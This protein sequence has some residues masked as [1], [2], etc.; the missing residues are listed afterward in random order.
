MGDSQLRGRSRT[1]EC[2]SSGGGY[3]EIR[4]FKSNGDAVD[5]YV[6]ARKEGPAGF[7]ICCFHVDANH[8]TAG[9][10]VA[11]YAG[12]FLVVQHGVGKFVYVGPNPFN[13]SGRIEISVGPGVGFFVPLGEGAPFETAT[14]WSWEGGRVS[15]DLIT[16]LIGPRPTVSPNDGVSSESASLAGTDS[17]SSLSLTSGGGRSTGSAGCTWP[18]GCK[19]N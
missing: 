16:P 11:L 5:I 6:M 1:T 17:S 9:F 12:E 13:A 19:P 4:C 8:A 7:E 2:E 18:P 10:D 14:N 3:G 15:F